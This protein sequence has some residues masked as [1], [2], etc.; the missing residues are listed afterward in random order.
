MAFDLDAFLPYRLFQ[1]AEHS[2]HL[3]FRSYGDRFDLGRTDWRVMFNIG[4]FGPL[5]A[6]DIC[7]KSGL[8]KT[9]VSRAIARLA[10]RGWVH[11]QPVDADRRRYDLCLTPA[12]ERAFAQLWALAEAFNAKLALVIGV[13]ALPTLLTQ[14]RA[15]EAVTPEPFEGC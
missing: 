11:R 8:E 9:K 14:L 15:L 12:G 2:S 13:E 7:L 1:A 4:R 3:F 10:K 5:S 6:A